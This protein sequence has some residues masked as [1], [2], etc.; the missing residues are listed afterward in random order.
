MVPSGFV[1]V[2]R[3]PLTVGGK[4][5]RRALPAPD[6]R[7]PEEPR[8]YATPR[9][10]VEKQLAAI[11]ADVL[12][13]EAVGTHDNFF[14]LGGHSLLAVRLLAAVERAFGVGLH[15]MT[16]FQNPTVA[17]FERL[18]RSPHRQATRPFIEPLRPGRPNQPPLV[19]APSIF[20]NVHEW[21]HVAELLRQGRP[22]YG[23]SVAGSQPYWPGCETLQDVAKG[24]AAALISAGWA[25]PCHLAGYSFG[26]ILAYEVARQLTA[27]GGRVGSVIVVDTG[28]RRA[29][30]HHGRSVVRDLSSMARNF[31]RWV[32]TNVVETPQQFVDRAR[33]ELRARLAPLLR[34]AR[35]NGHEAPPGD[36]RLA[37]I[38]DL[39][40]L[41][42]PDRE[43]LAASWRLVQTY[44]P[45][46][47]T[48]HVTLL[49]CR[50]RP[51]IHRGSPDLGW[52]DWVDGPLEIREYPG[53][54]KMVFTAK[55]LHNIIMELDTILA[56]HDS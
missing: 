53:N 28:L 37:G 7:R 15:L 14:D 23:L 31:P 12:G 30:P 55:Y 19:F 22:I 18:L 46:R 29:D 47:Y 52:G 10:A 27:A 17:Q 5:D 26:G 4:L 43:R 36:R 50:T 2:E 1:A 45:G 49:R 51:L 39:D 54:H 44:R 24:F 9:D 20:G 33:R 40:G 11:W 3:L 35:R 42:T 13:L 21:R 32:W 34:H 41:P 16:V 25:M 6:A 48:G 8:P 38:I 56:T